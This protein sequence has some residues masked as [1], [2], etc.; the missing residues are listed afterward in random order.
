MTDPIPEKFDIQE[1]FEELDRFHAIEP[2][3]LEREQPCMP[4]RDLF[5]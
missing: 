4:E 2:F 1:W 5:E 3:V